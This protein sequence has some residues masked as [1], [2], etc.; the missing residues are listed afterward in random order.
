M[1]AG[2]IVGFVFAII[3]CFKKEWAP[4][5]SPIYAVCEGLFIGGLSSILDAQFRGNVHGIVLQAVMLTLGMLGGRCS[6]LL[7][8]P[9]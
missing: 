7:Q 1:G 5:T 9:G 6:R 2:A 3:T 8:R 4:V